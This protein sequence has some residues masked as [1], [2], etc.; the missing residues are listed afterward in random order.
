MSDA[1]NNKLA[2]MPATLYISGAKYFFSRAP[3]PPLMV[4][5]LTEKSNFSKPLMQT[6]IYPLLLY[7]VSVIK[8]SKLMLCEKATETLDLCVSCSANDCNIKT[9]LGHMSK[10]PYYIKELSQAESVIKKKVEYTGND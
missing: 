4:R 5:S 1:R 6:Y 2:I 3:A 10:C 9:V 7:R 8:M